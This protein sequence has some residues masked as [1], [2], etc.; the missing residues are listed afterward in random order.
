MTYEEIQRLQDGDPVIWPDG[1]CGCQ[2][3]KGVVRFDAIFWDDQQIT[4]LSDLVAMKFVERLD[5]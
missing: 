2:E 5:R 1:A 3:A 4:Y